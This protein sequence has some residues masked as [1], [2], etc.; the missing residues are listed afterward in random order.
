MRHDVVED[1]VHVFDLTVLDDN[2][3]LLNAVNNQLE[4]V[5]LL[6]QDVL[7]VDVFLVQLL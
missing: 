7:L 6:A 5:S 4:G 1:G 2:D 3:S